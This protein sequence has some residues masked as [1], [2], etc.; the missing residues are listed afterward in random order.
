MARLPRATFALML[1][2]LPAT[3]TVVGL[4]VLGQVPTLHDIAGIGL[5]I[6]GVAV[7]HNRPGEEIGAHVPVGGGNSG[8]RTSHSSLTASR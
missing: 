5:V 4:L 7:H 1:A 6:V 2:L 3:A 8:H